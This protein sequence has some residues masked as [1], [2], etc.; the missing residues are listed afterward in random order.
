MQ[1]IQQQNRAQVT[2]IS[3]AQATLKK[4]TLTTTNGLFSTIFNLRT[5]IGHHKPQNIFELL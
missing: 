2:F 1:F 4:Q 3:L 5:L